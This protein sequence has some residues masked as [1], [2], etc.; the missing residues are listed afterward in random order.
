MLS[1]ALLTTGMH[2]HCLAQLVGAAAAAADCLAAA[3]EAQQSW[4]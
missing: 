3:L 2:Q 4:D 1:A